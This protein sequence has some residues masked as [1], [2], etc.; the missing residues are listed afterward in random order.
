MLCNV[1]VP[2]FVGKK[3]LKIMLKHNF[4]NYHVTEAK[5][6]KHEKTHAKIGCET[7]KLWETIV[8][9]QSF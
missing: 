6:Q 2:I 5:Q 9:Q 7:R 8:I 1:G 4:M 3:Y